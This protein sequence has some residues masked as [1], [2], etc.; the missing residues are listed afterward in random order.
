VRQ[1]LAGFLLLIA[2]LSSAA[3]NAAHPAAPPKE[4]LVAVHGFMGSSHAVVLR[5]G[6]LVYTELEGANK[7]QT[8][9]TPTADQ[10]RQFRETLDSLHVWRWRSKYPN[11]G[12]VADALRWDFD[13]TYADRSLHVEADSNF[14]D[15]AG[16]PTNSAQPSSAFQRLRTAVQRL[17]GNESF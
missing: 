3:P 15:D 2:S 17:I 13:V 5:E 9:T 7:R 6:V 14:P 8:R 10:W 4:L 12:G 16:R 11:P 1:F